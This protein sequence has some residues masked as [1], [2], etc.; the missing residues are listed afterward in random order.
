MQIKD[1]NILFFGT[2][3][4]AVPTLQKL[5]DNNYSIAAVVTQP[6]KP[7][8]RKQIITPPPVKLLAEKYN[9]PV[10]QPETLKS[11]SS[12]FPN[13]KSKISNLKLI[14]VASYGKIIPNEILKMSQFG[15]LNVHPSLLPKYRGPA[16]IQAAILNGDKETAVTIMLMDKEMD[17]GPILTQ[18]KFFI[19]STPTFL[20]LHDKL[21]SLGADLLIKTIPEWISGEITPIP[22]DD[23]LAAYTK[24]IKKDDG[25]ILWNKSAIEIERQIKAFTPWPGCWSVFQGKRIKIIDATASDKQISVKNPGQIFKTDKNKMIAVCDQGCLEILTLQLEGKKPISG[26]EFLRGHNAEKEILG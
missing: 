6:D 23:S 15:A 18:K 20:W 10:L 26:E 16:P 25:K 3:E 11:F 2:S 19:D 8:G 14:A 5:I 9:I 4:F 21:S 22:Q 7:V 13:L 1:I 12:Q 17:H 24:I